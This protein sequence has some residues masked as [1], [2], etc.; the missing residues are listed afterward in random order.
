MVTSRIGNRNP[1]ATAPILA[2]AAANP[3]PL[4]RIAVGKTSPAR[5]RSR[6][7]VFGELV[8]AVVRR[9]LDDG[10]N[11]GDEPF[12]VLPFRASALGSEVAHPVTVNSSS[13]RPSPYCM[14]QY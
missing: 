7:D 12:C 9:R 10:V 1:V 14:F 6:R 4:P 5:H 11:D 8:D 2:K 13:L 3:A